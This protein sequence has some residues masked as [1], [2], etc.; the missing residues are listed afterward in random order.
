MSPAMVKKTPST[1]VAYLSANGPY[2][3]IGAA[4]GQLLAAMRETGLE[5]VGPPSGVYFNSPKEVPPEELRW[6]IRC[7]VADTTPQAL[8]DQR[9]VAVKSVAEVEVVADIH[10]GPY[11]EVERTYQAL[12]Y[13]IEAKG[14]A[15]VGPPEEVYLSNPD[16]TPPQDLLTE[17][18][19][20][21]KRVRDLVTP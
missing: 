9:G 1:T 12:Y 4:M 19:I 6:E 17:I 14:Y 3:Q 2:S 15:I 10:R 20:P 7:P 13:W 21:V 8:P 11:Q 16:A 5:P 18:R